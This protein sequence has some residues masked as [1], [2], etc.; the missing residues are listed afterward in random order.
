[1][2]APL[3]SHRSRL[4]T[5]RKPAGSRCGRYRASSSGVR[6][7]AR[8]ELCSPSAAGA[9]GRTVS[10]PPRPS[11]RGRPPAAGGG[12]SPAPLAGSRE[13]MAPPGPQPLR[14]DSPANPAARLPDN[15]GEGFPP[16]T[17]PFPFPFPGSD[18]KKKFFFGRPPACP[19]SLANSWRCRS[20]SARVITSRWVSPATGAPQG[21]PCGPGPAW[22]RRSP[23]NYQ[24]NCNWAR[25]RHAFTNMT[26]SP[27]P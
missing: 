2:P 11:P 23:Q 10:A 27:P 5:G 7:R 13:E 22:A 19:L 24:G 1:M 15:R 18:K 12:R 20:R 16:P 21:D 8:P 25:Y 4:P 26:L 3:P 6:S 9:R 17:P 14:A